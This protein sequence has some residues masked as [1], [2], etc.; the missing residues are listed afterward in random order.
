MKELQEVNP[1][2][3]KASDAQIMFLVLNT[4]S[5]TLIPIS[6]LAMRVASGAKVPT[7]VFIP[8]ILA[9][10]FSTMTG[11]VYVAIRQRINL[12]NRV[13][14]TYLAGITAFIAGIIWYLSR[15]PQPMMA[16]TNRI[17]REFSAFSGD[18]RIHYT[19]YPKKDQS[20]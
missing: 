18:H 17:C 15:L 16:I 5:L 7:D 14:M 12:F 13:V 3:T 20:L 11:L 9:T 8:I 4:S 6:I 1:D 10:Y 2:Q 19:G